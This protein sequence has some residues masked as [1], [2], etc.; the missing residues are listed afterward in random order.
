MTSML[1]P[2]SREENFFCEAAKDA[3]SGFPLCI[4]MEQQQL[5]LPLGMKRLPFPFLYLPAHV[6]QAEWTEIHLVTIRLG[7]DRSVL[8]NYSMHPMHLEN[9]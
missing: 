4:E 6:T 2:G 3:A 1:A 5:F 7:L 9:Q 8:Q